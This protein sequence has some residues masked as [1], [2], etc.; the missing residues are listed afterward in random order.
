MFRRTGVPTCRVGEAGDRGP[1]FS[2]TLTSVTARDR[3][4]ISRAG[5]TVC[6]SGDRTVG[7]TA[8]GTEVSV[9]IST[10]DGGWSS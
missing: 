9:D 4:F 8:H 5:V 3:P 1:L 6:L 10:T 2:S 7:V